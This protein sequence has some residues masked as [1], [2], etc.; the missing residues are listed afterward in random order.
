MVSGRLYL[1]SSG[2]VVWALETK[3][4]DMGL[5]PLGLHFNTLLSVGKLLIHTLHNAGER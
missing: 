1:R 2:A 4:P 5:I 3:I